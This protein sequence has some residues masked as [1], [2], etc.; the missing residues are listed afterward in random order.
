MVAVELWQTYSALLQQGFDRTEAL[1][2]TSA[3]AQRMWHE[4]EE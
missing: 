1:W 2:I 4:H 3:V